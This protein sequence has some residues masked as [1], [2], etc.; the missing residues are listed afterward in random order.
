MRGS[1]KGIN[2][3]ATDNPEDPVYL[4]DS[5]DFKAPNKARYARVVALTL[6]F[7]SLISIGIGIYLFLHR[8]GYKFRKDRLQHENFQ[9]TV[10]SQTMAEHSS[11]DDCWLAL[12]G[13]VYDL[14][15]YA[16]IHPGPSSLIT[17]H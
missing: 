16:P 9:G 7:L 6:G 10:S 3:P 15:E 5:E 8:N 1:N 12:H 4:E 11:P 17:M 2:D 14:T 13:K